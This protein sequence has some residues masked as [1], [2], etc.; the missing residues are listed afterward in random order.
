MY[1]YCY[2]SK[3]LHVQSQQQK[4]CQKIW[5]MSKINRRWSDVFSLNFEHISHVFSRVFIA[6]FKQVNVCWDATTN[7]WMY[8]FLHKHRIVRSKQLVRTKQLPHGSSNPRWKLQKT[9]LCMQNLLTQFWPM[10][11]FH[12]PNK[13]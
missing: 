3:H 4:H 13:D 8:W 7:P 5:N 1:R 2:P 11:P 12:T 9:P 6:D 10:S